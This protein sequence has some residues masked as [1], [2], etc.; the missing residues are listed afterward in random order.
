[1]T[2]SLIGETILCC[3]GYALAPFL[4]YQ[5]VA[6]YSS[7]LTGVIAAGFGFLLQARF[8]KWYIWLIPMAVLWAWHRYLTA[9]PERRRWWTA[10]AG[11][12]VGLSWLYR[13]DY[14]TTEF[15][16]CLVFLVSSEAS[17]ARL[18]A[19]RLLKPVR[20]FAAGCV[21]L[22]LA[23]F[24]YL[25]ARVGVLAPLIY[26]KSTIEATLAVSRGMASPPPA[27][28]SV[29]VAYWTIPAIYLVAAVMVARR[30]WLSRLDARSW[31][32]FAAALSGMA[33]VH[34]A[35]HRMSPAHLL[36]V[37]P[38]AIVCAALIVSSL[39]EKTEPSTFPLWPR[40]LLRFAGAGIA[41]FLVVT[42]L[43][44]AQW[45]QFDLEAFSVSPLARYRSLAHPL[46][47]RGDQRAVALATVAQLTSP[48]DPILVFPLDCQFYAL[49]KRRISGRHSTYYARLFD[50]PRDTERNLAAIQQEMP[51]LIVVPSDFE[52]A[53]EES[54]DQL[55]REARQSHRAIEQ[56][57][58]QNY[59]RV[60]ANSGGV[61]VLCR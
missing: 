51:K 55:A 25:V 40:P 59:P 50:S 44:L 12:V 30:A 11:I 21:V 46:A 54:T 3:C 26:M 24:L 10:I 45:G 58:R 20:L 6:H 37:I 31:F 35:M 16:A 23:W 41:L 18:S 33:S 9:I 34:Q 13:P 57:I 48:D 52:R 15:F 8:Y 4:I 53:P 43:A 14:G 47:E 22:P 49:A 7:T 28:R 2:G 39:L 32:L 42:G 61:M 36:Q 38:A 29:I 1:M 56:F 60:V 5:L 17:R 19:A 27:I